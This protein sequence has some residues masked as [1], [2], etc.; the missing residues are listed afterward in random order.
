MTSSFD[1]R[2]YRD[3]FG[4]PYCRDDS[5]LAFFRPVADRIINEI[6]AR[7]ILDAGCAIG[8]LVELL[9]RGGVDAYG[10]DVS[11]YAI[12]RVHETVRDR[13]RLGSV[14]EEIDGWYDLIVCIEVFAHVAPPQDEAAIANFGR[15]TDAVLFSA[16]PVPPTDPRHL[17]GHPPEHFAELFAGQGFFRDHTFDASFIQPSAALYRRQTLPPPN[18]VRHYEARLRDLRQIE[19]ELGQAR[20]TIMHMEQSW[21]WKARR[22]WAW[23]TGR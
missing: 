17:N 22:P 8:L 6:G 19:R 13:C 18:L 12:E 4:R 7:R 10:F 14:N 9:H 5:W 21:F 2:Y 3:C 20:Q 15:H 1:E 11:S 23:L 16:T